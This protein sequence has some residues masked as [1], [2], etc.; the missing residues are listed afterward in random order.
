[1]PQDR[2]ALIHAYKNTPR[3]AGIGVVRNTANGKVLL[4]ASRDI[5]AL[6]NR[7]H[8]QLRLGAHPNVALRR[9]WA[10]LGEQAFAFEVVDTLTPK[11]TPDYDPADDLQALE[12]LWLEKLAPFDDRG[13]NQRPIP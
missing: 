7:H 9:D 2:K 8:A 6:L 1:M 12:Q 11:D 4:L 10:A 5:P 3:T 13:Y